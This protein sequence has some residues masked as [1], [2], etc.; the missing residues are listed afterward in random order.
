MRWGLVQ[1]IDV[2]GAGIE[3]VHNENKYLR[4]TTLP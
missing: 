1:A 2:V 4:C 3:L